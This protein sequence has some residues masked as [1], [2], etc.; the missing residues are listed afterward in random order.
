[1]NIHEILSDVVQQELD[2]ID[3]LANQ[4][5]EVGLDVFVT[6]EPK[7]DRENLIVTFIYGAKGIDKSV[8]V[9]FEPGK[10]KPIDLKNGKYEVVVD[11]NFIDQLYAYLEKL[12]EVKQQLESIK[13]ILDK[14]EGEKLQISRK[15]EFNISANKL[16]WN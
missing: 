9:R 2:Q 15:V 5:D 10:W 7:Q 13:T 11:K 4:Y 8:K 3:Q 1:M 16:R 12:P 6:D 14:L